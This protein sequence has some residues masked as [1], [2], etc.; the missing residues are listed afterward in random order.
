MVLFH[1]SDFS[2]FPEDLRDIFQRSSSMPLLCKPTLVKSKLRR[3]VT[4]SPHSLNNIIEVGAN[5]TKYN[6]SIL[7]SIPQSMGRHTTVTEYFGIKPQ[8]FYQS[9]IFIGVL[10]IK[11]S[12]YQKVNKSFYQKFQH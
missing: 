2:L 8:K 4:D 12:S 5:T 6:R 3:A 11:S 9:Q 7:Q 10:V 1:K